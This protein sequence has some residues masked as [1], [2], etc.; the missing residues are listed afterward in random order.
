MTWK[1]V[2]GKRYFHEDHG[3]T[4]TDYTEI[5]AGEYEHLSSL[6]YAEF[7]QIVRDHYVSDSIKWG[8]GFY[9]AR[10]FKGSDGIPYIGITRGKSCD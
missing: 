8:Y 10:V 7:S 9:G 4:V 2:T 3:G 5:T 1:T 6:G